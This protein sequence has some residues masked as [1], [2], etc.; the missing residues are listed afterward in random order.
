[1]EPSDSW[2]VLIN[3]TPVKSL[4]KDKKPLVTV[5]PNMKLF[6]CLEQLAYHN[7]LSA[8]I[9]DENGKFR[10]FVVRKLLQYLQSITVSPWNRMCLT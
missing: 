9:V 8:P 10:G 6:D 2:K 7:I 3:Q 1:M 5:E 4:L